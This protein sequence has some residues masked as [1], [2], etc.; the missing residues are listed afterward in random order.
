MISEIG[1]YRSPTFQIDPD[2]L[3][4]PRSGVTTNFPPVYANCFTTPFPLL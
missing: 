2:C 3:L 1:K 4:Q